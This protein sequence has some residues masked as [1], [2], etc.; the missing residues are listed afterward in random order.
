MKEIKLNNNEILNVLSK[1]VAKHR[2][3]GIDFDKLDI[4][5]IEWN[6]TKKK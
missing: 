4:V 5:K 3:N 1:Y 6:V 2:S